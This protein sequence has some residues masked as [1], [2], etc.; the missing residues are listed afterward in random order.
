[1]D[2]IKQNKTKQNNNNNN[3]KLQMLH[4]TPLVSLLSAVIF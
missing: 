4:Y 1:M 3:N 2:K